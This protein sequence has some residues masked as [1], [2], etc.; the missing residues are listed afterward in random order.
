MICRCFT[1]KITNKIIINENLKRCHLTPVE[2]V[3]K[4]VGKKY[5]KQKI[6]K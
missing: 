1:L 3:F 4:Q 5:D 6:K 2:I